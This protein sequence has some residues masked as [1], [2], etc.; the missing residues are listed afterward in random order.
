MLDD[1]PEQTTFGGWLYEIGLVAVL[2]GL[3]VLVAELS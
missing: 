1:D 2:V 3:I